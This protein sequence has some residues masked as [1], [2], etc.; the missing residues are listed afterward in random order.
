[1]AT[2]EAAI[3]SWISL[4]SSMTTEEVSEFM[5]WLGEV[6]KRVPPGKSVHECL[7][8]AELEELLIDVMDRSRGL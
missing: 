8:R 3:A 5:T 1:M 4:L 7:T 6:S 2:T